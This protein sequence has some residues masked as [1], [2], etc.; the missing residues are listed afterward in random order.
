[1]KI[2][3][4]ANKKKDI[5]LFSRDSLGKQ[6]ILKD[7]S[8]NPYYYEKDDKGEYIGYDGTKLKKCIVNDPSD[9]SK[10]RT[11]NSYSADLSYCKRYF[12]DK[13]DKLDKTLIKHFFWDIEIQCK[14]LP[15]YEKPISTISCISVYNSL[16]KSI[17]TFFLGDYNND[18]ELLNDFIKYIKDEK[19]DCMLAWNS[20]FDYYYCFTRFK[21]LTKNKLDLGKELSP[22]NDNRHAFQTK[23]IYYP[24]GISILDYL[25]MFR[26]VYMREE[27]YTLDFI[28][29]KHTGKGKTY[30]NVD[31]TKLS[32]EVKLRN[33]GD[34][35]IMVDLEN[36][37]NII[38]YFD[39]IRRLSKSMWEELCMNSYII[40]NLLFEE[41]KNKGVVLPNKPIRNDEKEEETF[42]GATRDCVETGKF[43]DIGKFD[44]GSAYPTMIANFCLDPQNIL[45]PINACNI[46]EYITIN[47][48]SFRQYSDALLPSLI[49]RLLVLKNTLKQEV[50][51]YLPETE[52]NKKAQVKYDAIKGIVN[53]AFGAMALSSFRYYSQ[54]VASTI[55][56]L[57]RELLMY[58]KVGIE[59]E[60][61]KV[62]YFDTDSIFLNTKENISNKLNAL[63]QK[64][65]KDKYN[66]DSISIEFEFEGYFDKLFLLAPTRYY[67]YIVTSKGS[68]LEIKGIEA[69][70]ASSSKYE[71]EYQKNLLEMILNNRSKEDI[72]MWIEEEKNRIKILP[73]IDISFPC[74]KLDKEYKVKTIAIRSLENTKKINTKF[75]V[76]N[77][78]RFYYIFIDNPSSERD[79]LAFNE[80]NKDM[81]KQYKIDWR[82][83]I[84][85]NIE[86]KTDNILK[87]LGWEQKTGLFNL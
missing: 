82:K 80:E 37:Y 73:L 57:V 12:I 68:K 64:W 43:F 7:S 40:E 62:L 3:N 56:F 77:G 69:K 65:A 22:V 75:K 53:S 50:N 52:D 5:Y 18:L 31:F 44:L 34:V 6:I 11:S 41:A 17:Q 38:P 32:E 27:S 14:E 54:E 9:I 51:K 86:T 46:K 85:R 13:V 87:A 8:F 39:E 2:L 83:M 35:Q 16:S 4:I 61:Y 71:K 66:K 48:I 55:T 23:D 79:V 58:V 59:V 19:P 72:L 25:A 29:E 21:Y 30:K 67:G 76:N 10:F 26:K 42:Q 28:G 84:E 20:N 33:I 36:K 1:M 49:K 24:S 81:L 60:G 78:E 45:N 70:R 15:T 74:K 47:H 63:I